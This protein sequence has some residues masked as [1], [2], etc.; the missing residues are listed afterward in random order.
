MQFLWPLDTKQLLEQTEAVLLFVT[1][2]GDMLKLAS[3]YPYEVWMDGEFVGDGGFRCVLGK[4]DYEQWDASQIET[5]IVRLHWLNSE[6]TEV[7]Y[8]CLF[9]DAFLVDKNTEHVWHCYQENSITFAA[10]PCVQLPRQNRI[11]GNLQR[12][13]ALPLHSPDL[14]VDWQVTKPLIN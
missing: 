2:G 4:V 11:H 3:N 8:R 10:K 14:K 5:V 12:G 7:Y 9:E 6:K 13:T 1:Q